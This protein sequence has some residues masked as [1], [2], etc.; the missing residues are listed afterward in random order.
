MGEGNK[1]LSKRDPQSSLFHHRDRGFIPE[2]LL[3]YLALL[4][5][6]IADDHDIFTLDEMIAA[7]DISKVNSNPARFDQ[8]KADSINAEHIR[9]LAPDDFARRLRDFLVHHG[10]LSEP[11]DEAQ[12]AVVADLVQ[13]RIQVLGDAWG[14]IA[15]LYVSDDDFSDRRGGGP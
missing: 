15:F 11:I 10:Q 12:W 13:T 6:G 5:W 3:N 1:K 4:G 2:G 9:R 8:K 14:L 7:F